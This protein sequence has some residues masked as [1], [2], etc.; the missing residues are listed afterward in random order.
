[1]ALCSVFYQR[2]VWGSPPWQAAHLGGPGPVGASYFLA[3]TLWGR[4]K[5]LPLTLGPTR[6]APLSQVIHSF[7][8]FTD[9]FVQWIWLRAEQCRS[10]EDLKLLV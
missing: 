8:V 10:P 3:L 9:S 4:Q 1:M 5:R 7:I 2:S 6:E